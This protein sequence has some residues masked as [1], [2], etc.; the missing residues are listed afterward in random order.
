MS[1]FSAKNAFSSIH[2][3]VID[4]ARFETEAHGEEGPE[5]F[6]FNFVE[7]SLYGSIDLEGSSIYP[8]ESN[9]KIIQNNNEQTTFM[10]FDFVVD[11]INDVRRNIKMAIMLGNVDNDN[12]FI[13]KLEI[14]RAYEPPKELYVSYLKKILREFNDGIFANSKAL[15]NITSFDQYVKE[16]L[17]FL[18]QNYINKPLTFSGWLQSTNNSLF[19]T[20]LAV[21]I[22][23]IKFDDDNA[24]YNKFMNSSL[25]PFYKKVC[26]NRGF[27]VW[28]H[29]PYVL[30][31]DLG[32]PAIEP[33]VNLSISNILNN[34]YSKSYNID[35][36]YLYNNIIEYYNNMVLS[37]PYE[38]ILNTSCRK[39]KRNIIYRSEQS[40]SDIDHDY[41]INFYIDIR[42]LELGNLK[43]RAEI[44]KIKKYLKNLQNSLDNSDK[45]RYIDSNFRQETFKKSF[46][47]SDSIRRLEAAEK[48]RDQEEGIT[49][50]STIV[51]GTTSGGY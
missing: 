7:Y 26:L 3:Q 43:G 38:I 47:I 18:S 41:W 8:T 23:D 1:R 13:E 11:M 32:S 14:F 37:K 6:E 2:N 31:A 22:A 15:I 33:Y 39:T 45:I 24:K 4:K 36:I 21:S 48:Q 34:Y 50:G 46:G 25:F 30:V 35:Y 10:A 5:V 20:G 16:F 19:S 42:N 12:N 29:C 40:I 27:K 17:I 49:G 44:K 51:G 9:M 28:K